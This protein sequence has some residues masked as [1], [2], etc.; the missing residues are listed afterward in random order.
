MERRRSEPPEA[1]GG[2][3][4]S[5]VIAT[6]TFRVP[7]LR[8]VA[9]QGPAL[10]LTPERELVERQEAGGRLPG[11]PLPGLQLRLLLVEEGAAIE[12]RRG[13][14]GRRASAQG[15][16]LLLLRA[17]VPAP[18]GHDVRDRRKGAQEGPGSRGADLRD[19][20][21]LRFRGGLPFRD[22]VVALTQEDAGEGLVDPRDRQDVPQLPLVV[23][24]PD[25]AG[26]PLLPTGGGRGR[27]E[28]APAGRARG[29]VGAEARRAR[30]ALRGR[31]VRLRQV[32][33]QAPRLAPVAEDLGGTRRGAFGALD[34]PVD[35]L[36]ASEDRGGPA[37]IAEADGE[38]L[39][40]A[41]GAG[42]EGGGLPGHPPDLRRATRASRAP[43]RVG[44]IW[45]ARSK[46]NRASSGFPD[47]TRMR[48]FWIHASG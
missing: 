2:F 42:R 45:R 17:R 9:P 48:P 18:R 38:E 21:E 22:R 25:P 39:A 40:P 20:G 29:V 31:G 14:E 34:D 23:V 12:A 37:H 41:P 35:L 47:A 30:G 19:R 24:A 7:G 13:E 43:A 26:P 10:R 46:Q 27:P 4:K 11:E 1:G 44:R 5:R 36:Q 15:A 6:V 8:A 33:E 16:F 3:E 28:G 32:R